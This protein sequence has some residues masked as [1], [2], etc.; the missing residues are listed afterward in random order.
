MKLYNIDLVLD[1]HNNK[2]NNIINI[3][4]L[5]KDTIKLINIIYDM[6]FIKF[7]YEKKNTD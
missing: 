4:D 2:S 1:I 7:N 5:S 6:D 3:K